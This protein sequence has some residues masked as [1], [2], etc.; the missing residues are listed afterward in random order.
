M[1]FYSQLNQDQNVLNYYQGEKCG[2]F[3]EIGAWDG[4]A[5]SNT[6]ALEKL[7][8]SGICVEPLPDRYLELVKNRT[9]KTYNLAVDAVGGKT[10]DF[11]VLGMLSG[12]VERLD[13]QRAN[14]E[15]GLGS[16]ISVQTINFTKLLDDAG[17]PSFIEFLSLD[18]EG[19]EYDILMGLDFE[20]YRF[21]Y[22]SVEHNF[23][24]PARANIRRL[25][26][27]K[28]YTFKGENQWDDDYICQKRELDT[29]M[30]D[31]L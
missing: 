27:S 31:A 2:Y 3:V 21:G 18:T 8:W 14:K 20:K 23:K 28:G 29:R 22:I 11:V 4:I 5:L 6:Y 26:T 25:L 12:D 7:G 13:I 16:R 9:C 17:A 24:E 10:L 30:R 1:E 15:G 19:S